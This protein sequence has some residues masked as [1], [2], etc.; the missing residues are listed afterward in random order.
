MSDATKPDIVIEAERVVEEREIGWILGSIP[1]DEK[2]HF[3]LVPI[4]TDERLDPLNFSRRRKFIGILILSL[5]RSADCLARL[6][7]Q[8]RHL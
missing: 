4:P 3:G 8:S 5:C 1:L 2:G 7:T 6:M